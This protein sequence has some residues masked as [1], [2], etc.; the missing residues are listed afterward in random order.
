MFEIDEK[1]RQK[2]KQKVPKTAK[3]QIQIA[4]EGTV[5]TVFSLHSVTGDTEIAQDT[6][7]LSVFP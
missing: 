4:T 2:L 1:T 3:N 5:S 6:E 7:T